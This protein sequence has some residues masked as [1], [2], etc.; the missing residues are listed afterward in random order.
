MNPFDYVKSAS[1][2]KHFIFDAKSNVDYNC[3]I[4]NR[5]FSYYPDCIFYAQTMNSHYIPSSWNYKYYFYEI[6]KRK[7]F[8]PWHKNSENENLDLI[9]K[10]YKYSDKKALET[11]K[12]LTN[13]Q[14][15]QL[16]QYYFLG[17][18]KTK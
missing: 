8:S 9:K 11:L 18:I 15:E 6:P 16:K 17:G 10:I 4:V 3:F 14:I 5:A 12:V 13:S 7:R 1:E 2:T